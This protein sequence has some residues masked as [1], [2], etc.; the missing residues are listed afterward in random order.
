MQD[1]IDRVVRILH[2]ISANPQ[3]GK[4]KLI[5]GDG[6]FPQNGIF[7]RMEIIKEAISQGKEIKNITDED[8]VCWRYYEACRWT[9]GNLLPP[10]QYFYIW[11]LC[12]NN[13]VGS[14]ITTNYDLYFDSIFYKDSIPQGHIL[15]PIN[16][17][18]EYCY[19]GFFGPISKIENRLRLW[20]IHGS[21]SYASFMK[22]NTSD[23]HIFKLPRFLV[24]FPK[25]NPV[26]EFALKSHDHLGLELS[27][28]GIDENSLNYDSCDRLAHFT[29]LNFNRSI[30][31]RI[32]NAAISDLSAEDTA[33]ILTLG[34]TGYYDEINKDDSKNEELVPI[35]LDLAHKIPVCQ[36][37]GSNQDPSRS[38]LYSKLQETSNGFVMKGLPKFMLRDILQQFL[39][40]S[41]GSEIPYRECEE[42]YV[43]RWVCGPLFSRLISQ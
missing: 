23:S 16:E 35:I 4:L 31:S 18:H 13:L 32:I 27:G 34:F 33:F 12:S 40:L 41:T 7:S 37:L 30:F 6:I 14:I 11:K 36:I 43:K 5:V 21:L 2:E 22:S 8:R 1:K 25:E 28:S 38:F 39:D 19:E 9:T 26:G 29:D 15:N 10:Q 20:K 17:D 42:Y 3:K 24:G